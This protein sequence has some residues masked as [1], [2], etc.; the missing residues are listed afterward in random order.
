MD[1]WQVSY[2]RQLAHT[3]MA[4]VAYVGSRGDNLRLVQPERGAAGSGLAGLAPAHPGAVE[5]VQHRPER[6]HQQV[7]LQQP[8]DQAAE[9]LSSG[10]QF[11][12]SYTLSKSLD[13][14]GRRRPAAAPSAGQ[15]VTRFDQSRGPSGFD[16][17]PPRAEPR[18]GACRF[19]KDHRLAS[20]GPRRR[21]LRQLAI[22][23]DR[24]L[25]HRS[26]LHG[27]P[28]HGG[29]QRRAVMAEPHRRRPLDNPTVNLWFDIAA[30][31]P[32]PPNT[33]GNSGAWRPQRAAHQDR[34]RL[35]GPAF[36]AHGDRVN[37]Q[38]RADA[39]NLL[40]T[41]QFGFPNANIGVADRGAHHHHGRRQPPDAVRGKGRLVG[42]STRAAS[43]G[44]GS[45]A[46]GSPRARL[47][48]RCR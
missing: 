20:S 8:P 36:P 18:V 22:Q 13:S 33:Y 29:E 44:T 28:E 4:E 38:F 7:V 17:A 2:E 46:A 43:P 48:G 12:A 30:F 27:V 42:I 9:A 41:P 6:V 47:A 15:T 14:A 11:L 40:N 31:R 10:V 26:A 3:L 16:Q 25:R 1:T 34:G 37:L 19:G 24:H 35:A 23:R 45:R 5:R 21:P 39:F 32:P